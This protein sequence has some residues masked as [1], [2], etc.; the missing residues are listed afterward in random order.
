VCLLAWVLAAAAQLAFVV[1][2]PE[3]IVISGIDVTEA[4]SLVLG[5]QA[6]FIAIGLLIA[7][8]G[9]FVKRW[10]PFLVVA[11]AAFYLLHWFPFRAVSTYGVLP[12][13]K[14]MFLVGSSTGLQLLSITRD[15]VLPLAFVLSIVLVFVERN[16]RNR[17]E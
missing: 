1:S 6:I 7:I 4:N 3:R 14:A 16:Q 11:A 8:A 13:A 10:S 15:L 5:H 9:H 12:V 17:M 2:V